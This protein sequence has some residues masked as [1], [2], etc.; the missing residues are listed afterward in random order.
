MNVALL[1]HLFDEPVG[2]LPFLGLVGT[3]V[4]SRNPQETDESDDTGELS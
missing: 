2:L 3:L 4:Q 1:H